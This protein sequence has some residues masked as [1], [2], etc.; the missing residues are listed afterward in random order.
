MKAMD[1]ITLVKPDDFHLH[2]RDG[3]RL[4]AV[5]GDSARR[6]A[7][8]VVMPNLAPPVVSVAQARAYRRR[9]LEALPEA[10][11]FAPLMTLY[12]TDNTGRDEVDRVLDSDEVYAFKYYPAGATTNSSAGVTDLAR[13]MPLLEYMAAKDVPLLAHGEAT[14]PDV[15]VFDR[16]RVFIEQTLSPLVEELD[17]LRVVLE[18]ITT[19][20]AVQF[21]TAAPA[22][23][24]A[25]ITPHHLLAN[26]NAMFSG[27]VNPHNYC[28]PVLKREEHRQAL[29]SAACGGNPKFFAGTDSAPHARGDK[30][31]ACGC[32]GVYT[33]CA[34]LELYAAA[35]EETDALGAL[36]GFVSVHGARFYG[37]PPNEA[38]I[39]LR[40]RDWRIPETLPYA[41][42]DLVPFMAG[43]FCRWELVD[44]AA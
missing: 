22:T 12:L 8:A 11:D 10:T 20:E 7:R 30:E 13:V 15:D 1:T 21:I 38:K 2:L 24:A 4:A 6:F 40:R 37:L 18:H 5:V 36:E 31:S 33:A 43:A 17:A 42:A 39:T 23:A 41:G 44:G 29:L 28:L 9:I 27:G 16:E 19:R 26:R 25:T 34:A 35:F 3:E 14:A 32:A